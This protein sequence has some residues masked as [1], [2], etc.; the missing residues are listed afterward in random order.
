[1]K[2]LLL[3]SIVWDGPVKSS[4]LRLHDSITFNRL[5]KLKY[6]GIRPGL[7]H[8]L[9]HFFMRKI[10]IALLLFFPTFLFAQ[11]VPTTAPGNFTTNVSGGSSIPDEGTIIANP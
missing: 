2:N 9:Y 10:W 3:T 1:M 8:N 6:K 5:Y 7:P 11:T 4:I